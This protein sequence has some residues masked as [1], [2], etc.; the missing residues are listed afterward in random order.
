MWDSRRIFKA[1]ES[2]TTAVPHFHIKDI[3]STSKNVWNPLAFFEIGS[4]LQI[5]GR[6]IFQRERVDKELSGEPETGLTKR[7]GNRV[8]LDGTEK[9]L[10]TL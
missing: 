2:V 7:S 8:L 6:E 5:N 10:A 4:M 1:F 9:A 3:I